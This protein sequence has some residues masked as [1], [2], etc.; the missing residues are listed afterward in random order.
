MLL[1]LRLIRVVHQ[2]VIDVIRGPVAAA[3]TRHDLISKKQ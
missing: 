3:F 2:V 1:C